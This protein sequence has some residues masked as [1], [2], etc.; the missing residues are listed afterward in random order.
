MRRTKIVITLGPATDTPKAIEGLINVGVDVFRLNFSHG[1]KDDHRKRV[2]MIREQAA[3]LNRAVGILG[4][5]QGPKIRITKFKEGKVTLKHGAAFILDAALPDGQG[6]I[7]RVGVTYPELVGDVEVGNTLVLDDGRVV[8]D[9]VEVEGD[10]IR[11]TVSVGGVLSNNKGINL[12][13]GGLSAEA[14]GDKDR[15]DIKL[16]AEL[17]VDFLGVSFPRTADDINLAR[18][19]NREAGGNAGIVAK[20]ERA[21]ALTA[22]DSILEATDAIM[23]ARGDLGVEIGDAELPAVQK[24]LINKARSA[25]KIVITATQM[26]ESMIENPI[27]TRAEV[28]DVANAVLD[29]TDAVMLSGETAVGNHPI[30]A[31][32]AMGEICES[33]EQH[34]T[35]RV[36]AHRMDTE[37]EEVDE[38]IAMATMYT[39]NHLKVR[40]IAALTESG[41]TTRWMSRISSIMPIYALTPH[42]STCRKVTLY[43]GVY[44]VKFDPK[45]DSVTEVNR[46]VLKLLHLRGKADKGDLVVITKGDV[47]GVDGGTSSM[48]I[49][50]MEDWVE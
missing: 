25:N 15:E 6:D 32:K 11:T 39:A 31:V 44:P 30:K 2:E 29:G 21:E 26:M 48:K 20:I 36:S 4:D 8:L 40:A 45:H 5:L 10:E 41:R 28:F 23:V 37:F 42:E 19:L 14:I 24:D 33:A 17:G 34:P 46:D 18:S 43:R 12:K 3:K 38:A 47:M 1:E 13:G 9:V 50:R 7:E 35:A 49:A 27:P 16:A 22:I